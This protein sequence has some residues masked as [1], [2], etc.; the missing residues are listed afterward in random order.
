MKTKKIIQEIKD[1][2]SEITFQEQLLRELGKIEKRRKRR[3]KVFS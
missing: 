2:S 1:L 3:E